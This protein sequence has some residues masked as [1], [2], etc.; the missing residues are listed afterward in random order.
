MQFGASRAVGQDRPTRPPRAETGSL[1][2]VLRRAAIINATLIKSCMLDLEG[3]Q[4]HRF[5]ERIDRA[6]AALGQAATTPAVKAAE[7]QIATE[8][9]RQIGRQDDVLRQRE[10]EF[11]KTVAL[12]TDALVQFRDSSAEFTAEVVSRTDSMGR[13]MAVDDIRMLREMLQREIEGLRDTALERQDA[14]ARQLSAL[15]AKVASLELRLAEAVGQA[16]RD[17][18]T[19][20]ASRAAWDQRMADFATLLET[21]RGAVAIAMIDLDRFKQINDDHGHLTGDA[22]LAH[23]AALCRRTLGTH[24]FVA[25]YG[26][27]EFAA[28]LVT[29]TVEEAVH[30]LTTLLD[31]VRAKG[32]TL[33]AGL[34][35]FT[36][37]IGLA[38]ATPRDTATTLIDRADRAL[39]AAKKGGRDQLVVAAG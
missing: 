3:V 36:I 39:Y 16:G 9:R 32:S 35:P 14:D 27:D 25:R 26:G 13:L 28:L 10:G 4:L 2:L 21:E 8:T 7:E 11:A 1:E 18:L 12:L 37:S 31:R 6:I 15:S 20:L 5:H 23:A 33:P 19:G 24:G 22:V 34:V 30:R 38:Y 17:G 29:S